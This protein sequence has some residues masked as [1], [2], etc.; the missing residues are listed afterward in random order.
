MARCVGNANGIK[1]YKVPQQARALFWPQD[2]P[3]ERVAL[4]SRETETRP[5]RSGNR[6]AAWRV[7]AACFG[8]TGTS[9]MNLPVP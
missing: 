7:I 2:G 6:F 3:F 8:R 1:R 5:R 9:P 4:T